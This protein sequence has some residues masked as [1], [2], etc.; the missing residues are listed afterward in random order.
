MISDVLSDAISNIESYLGSEVYTDVYTGELRKEIEQL[1]HQMNVI[2]AYLDTPCSYF[3]KFTESIEDYDKF[4]EDVV[5][6]LKS[7]RAL[8]KSG[9]ATIKHKMVFHYFVYSATLL[10]KEKH[11]HCRKDPI[12]KELLTTLKTFTQLLTENINE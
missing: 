8:L 5:E 10:M 12:L 11:N 9:K 4:T 2:R 7:K 1:V 6:M 3:D